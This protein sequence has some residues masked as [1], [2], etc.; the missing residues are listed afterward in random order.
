M[1][2]AVKISGVSLLWE[3]TKNTLGDG[4]EWKSS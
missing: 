1:S 2:L 4:R 3:E